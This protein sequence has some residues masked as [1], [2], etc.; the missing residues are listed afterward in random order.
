MY[1]IR[2]YYDL[3]LADDECRE[4]LAIRFQFVRVFGGQNA[5]AVDARVCHLD[6]LVIAL[7]ALQASG[8]CDPIAKEPAFIADKAAVGIDFLELFPVDFAVAIAFAVITSYSIHYTKLYER[9][10]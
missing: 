6:R 8:R 9:K 1:A 5:K 2:S 4:D 3:N 7:P 10:T